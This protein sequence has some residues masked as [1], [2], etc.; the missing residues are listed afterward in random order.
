MSARIKQLNEIGIHQMRGL[1][2][3][4]NRNLLK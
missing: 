1:S 2:E 4:D 3:T